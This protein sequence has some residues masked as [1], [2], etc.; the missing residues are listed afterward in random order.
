MS[1]PCIQPCT[2]HSTL[3]KSQYVNSSVNLRTK[4]FCVFVPGMLKCAGFEKNVFFD[5]KQIEPK[6]NPFRILTRKKNFPSFRFKHFFRI[7]ADNISLPFRFISLTVEAKM[8]GTPYHLC[9][10]DVISGSFCRQSSLFAV[11]IEISM[12]G[13]TILEKHW[14]DFLQYLLQHGFVMV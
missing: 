11:Q 12:K 13:M 4:L 14:S 1:I 5:W 6:P 10:P 3:R 2:A 7:E 8:N 9:I